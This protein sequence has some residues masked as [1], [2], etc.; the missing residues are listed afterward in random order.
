MIVTVPARV[1]EPK[2]QV[3]DT[4]INEV[5]DVM[6]TDALVD[7]FTNAHGYDESLA[8]D[9]IAGLLSGR[10]AQFPPMGGPVVIRVRSGELPPVL[11]HRLE[12]FPRSR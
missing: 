6:T 9:I 10:V 2:F 11:G 7:Y 3:E 1:S 8:R 4:E 12:I 5:F